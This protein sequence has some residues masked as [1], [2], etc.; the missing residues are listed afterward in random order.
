MAD[1]VRFQ[2]LDEATRKLL[3]GLFPHWPESGRFG[4]AGCMLPTSYKDDANQFKT[5]TV[6]PDDIWVTTIPR[7]GTT[8][9]QELVWLLKNDLDY[10]K[11]SKSVLD[12]RYIFTGLGLMRNKGMGAILTE[13]APC[14]GSVMEALQNEPSPRFIKNHFPLSLL[15]GNLL[16][17][18]KVV[19]VARDPRD[20]AVSCYHLTKLLKNGPENFKLFWNLF[21]K[22]L[23]Q[24]SPFFPH[25]KE[26][27][28]LRHHPHMFFI[29][30]KE[31]SKDMPS[32]IKRMAKF[33]DKEVT[34]EQV[35]KLCDH[36]NID[37]F[38]KNESVNSMWLT[39]RVGDPDAESFIRKGKTGGWREH[40][41]EE[42]TA[43]AQQW[44]RENLSDCDLRFPDADF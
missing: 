41:D 1:K 6:R 17:T 29:F 37:N 24:Y 44:M 16:D 42:M 22:N 32:C 21:I 20:V 5:M 7:S 14:H 35:V 4:D 9:A 15:P 2:E 3:S 43:Q 19:Y 39:R 30:Y 26:A 8:L 12:E 11:A 18:A 40:F 10:E 34:D 13:K 38:R 23:L 27:W 25:L 31:L 36:L 33:L 28:A